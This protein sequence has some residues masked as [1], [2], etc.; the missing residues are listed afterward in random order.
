MKLHSK[1]NF[2]LFLY[3]PSFIYSFL[4]YCCR[5]NSR[6]R[7]DLPT[8]WDT[9]W[10]RAGNAYEDSVVNS[11]LAYKKNKLHLML[12]SYL[13]VTGTCIANEKI[14]KGKKRGKEGGRQI[15]PYTPPPL[16]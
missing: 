14:K 8:H 4:H 3:L 6:H 13:S 11:E 2:K 10:K 7:W 1:N 5:P 15:P 9:T 12:R 16:S